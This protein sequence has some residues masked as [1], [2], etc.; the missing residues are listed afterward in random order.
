MNKIYLNGSLNKYLHFLLHQYL[1]KISK[2]CT[3]KIIKVI[4]FLLPFSLKSF[5]IPF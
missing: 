4:N 5:I 1:F 3:K 2:L